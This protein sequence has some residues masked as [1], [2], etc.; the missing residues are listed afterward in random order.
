MLRMLRVLALP[1]LVLAAVIAFGLPAE[2]QRGDS[3]GRPSPP[4]E[5]ASK[6]RALTQRPAPK[7]LNAGAY[8]T[9]YSEIRAYAESFAENL[10]VPSEGSLDDLGLVSAA[11][12]GGTSTS[13]LEFVMISNIRCDWYRVALEQPQSDVARQ[14]VRELPKWGP[15][16]SST[17]AGPLAERSQRIANALDAGVTDALQ[18]EVSGPNCSRA[19]AQKRSG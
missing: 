4:A 19:A 8:L 5:Q 12:Q 13:L 15:Y 6:S 18:A 1:A 9:T 2:A 11:E 3:P 7:D 10:P 17:V 14:I 16:K